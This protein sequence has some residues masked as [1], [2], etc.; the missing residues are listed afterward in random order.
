MDIDDDFFDFQV[1]ILLRDRFC[2][3]I[4]FLWS[5]FSL[6]GFIDCLECAISVWFLVILSVVHSCYA[7]FL[8]MILYKVGLFSYWFLLA[9]SRKSSI[10]YYLC[11]LQS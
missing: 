11:H 10:E 4:E 1:A 5:C 2:F 6:C 7:S 8:D 9:P 3:F